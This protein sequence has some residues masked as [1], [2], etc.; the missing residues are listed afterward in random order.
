MCTDIHPQWGEEVVYSCQLDQVIPS[1][2]SLTVVMTTLIICNRKYLTYHNTANIVKVY[3]YAHTHFKASLVLDF[4]SH[5]LVE[6][7]RIE[8]PL[9]HEVPSLFQLLCFLSV[10]ASPHLQC[11]YDTYFVVAGSPSLFFSSAH[12][13]PVYTTGEALVVTYMWHTSFSLPQIHKSARVGLSTQC[14]WY[15]INLHFI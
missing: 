1:S 14:H 5:S 15:Q 8:R 10:G 2:L 12:I 3:M 11:N 7:H 9:V 6:H 4:R 13:K